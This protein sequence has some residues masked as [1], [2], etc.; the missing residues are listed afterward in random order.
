M[1]KGSNTGHG[2]VWER[3]DGVKM[4]CGGPKE[5]QTRTYTDGTDGRG[6][7]MHCAVFLDFENLQESPAE[8]DIDPAKAVARL[9]ARSGDPS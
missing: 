5:A 3:P 4:R 2:H 9:K 6:N 8:F 7:P 1:S